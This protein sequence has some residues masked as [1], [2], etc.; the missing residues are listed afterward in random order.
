MDFTVFCVFILS[1]A[2]NPSYSSPCRSGEI[3]T[4]CVNPCN[5]CEYKGF[6]NA[7][8]ECQEGCDC[9]P[10]HY[11]NENGLCVPLDLCKAK[12][13]KCPK[14]AL[15]VPCAPPTIP[16]C[17]NPYSEQD[18]EYDCIPGCICKPGFL[19]RKDSTC[20]PAS[21]CYAPEVPPGQE[22]SCQ[23]NEDYYECTPTC[24]NTCQNFNISGTKCG[25]G[26]PGC[27]CKE[28]LVKRADG[29]CVHPQQCL[30]SP[31]PN[32]LSAQCPKNAIFIQC[33]SPCPPTCDD[34]Q[35]EPCEE[36][37]TTAC[38]C[39]PGYLK[40]KD[41]ICVIPEDCHPRSKEKI[42]QVKCPENAIFI[43]CGSP[44]PPTCEN[45]QP[46]P[47]EEK[48]TSACYC[49]PGYLKSKENKCVKPENCTASVLPPANCRDDEEYYECNPSCKNTCENFNNPGVKCQCGPPGCFCKRGLVKRADGK[50]ILPSQCTVPPP[51]QCTAYE[52]YYECTPSC[53]NTCEHFNNSR[54]RCPCGPPGCFCKPG[55]VKKADGKC[56][57][58]NQCVVLPPVN[59]APHEHFYE[60]TPSCKNTCENFNNPGVNCR[61]GP[62][63]CFC[64]KGLVKRMDGMCVLPS[65]CPVKAICR[66]NAQFSMCKSPCRPT[67]KNPSPTPCSESCVAGCFCKDGFLEDEDGSCVL[68]QNCRKNKVI[69]CG[70]DQKY[71]ECTPSCKNTCENFNN[72]SARCQCGPPGCFCKSGLVKRAD[73]KCVTPKECPV[74][75]V[76]HANAQFSMCKSPCRPT[77]KNPSPAPCTEPCV[78]GCFCKDGYVEDEDGRCVL[79][80]NCKKNCGQDEQF[81]ACTPNCK[82]T[83]ENFD[84]PGVRCQCGP[85]GCFCKEG[86]VKRADG[87]CVF[88]NQCPVKAS[89]RENAQFSMCRSPCRPTC[90]NPYPNPCNE[91]CVAGCFCKDGF[92]EDEDGSCVLFEKCKKMKAICRANAQFSMCRTPCRPTCKNPAP[93]PCNE[94]CVAGCFCTDGFV[95]DQDGRCVHFKNCTRP[96]PPVYCG[97]DEEYYQ[98]TPSCKNTCENFNNP[99]V[100]CQCGPPGCFCRKGLIK[101]A[102]GKCV[103]PDRCPACRANAQFS[104]CQPPCQPTCQN[105]YPAPCNKPCV[106]GCFCKPGF[107]EE[108]DGQCVLFQNCKK[109]CGQDEEYYECT[110]SCKNTCE[111]FN[112]PGVKCQC[113]P[114]GCFCKRGLIKRMD[115]KC[116]L[117]S[118]CPVKAICRAN[119]QFSMCKS[120]CRPTCKN[121]SPA[122]CNERCV[123]GCFCE[124]GYVEE[125]DGRCVLFQNCRKNCGQD[126]QYYE[127]TPSCKNTCD[128]FN[129]PGVRCQCGPPGCFCKE[130]LVKRADGK[131][132]HPRQ[133]PANVVCRTNAQFSMCQPPCRPTCQNPSPAPCNEP[134]VSGC[135]CKPGFVEDEDGTCVPYNN[136]KKNCGQDMQYYECTPSCKNTCENFKNPAAKCQCGPPGCFCKEGLVKRAD[137]KCVYPNQCPVIAV[138][139]ANAQFWMCKSPCRPTCDNPAPAPCNLPCVAGCFCKPGF[140]EDVDGRCVQFK[141]C[142]KSEYSCLSSKGYDTALGVMMHPQSGPQD[143]LGW[144]TPDLD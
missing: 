117:P 81:Y 88:P 41:G 74:K 126:E 138:C 104:E 78:A 86:L 34:L 32:D 94:P 127:C 13:M 31:S 75:A 121:P 115:G 50:C 33:G 15:Y 1:S 35:P 57:H 89:C 70:P 55:L 103:L 84:N 48:C 97:Q 112:N 132:V 29:K 44:C 47:C 46:E 27:F 123:S 90:K 10:Q 137:G 134:C 59:C 106:S 26:P 124:D 64:K 119:A 16:S 5:T 118:Q 23:E 73:G 63:G 19:K 105:P 17:E 38:Y 108:E 39:K 7:P 24:R 128:N 76:C 142:S 98:C 58:P 53:K 130:G 120:P 61:C 66:T 2:V 83:C 111:H 139:R 87:K 3:W 144:P 20:V 12:T 42:P 102:D 6:C 22:N 92:V 96:L 14:N 49:K 79:F 52:Q 125:E 43:Q 30:Q 141:N 109:N 116:V 113:G 62:P 101:R 129:N 36:K 91:P 140:V 136:C 135:F 77:C 133:C 21:Q 95:E 99:G 4:E 72:P 9:K 85:P 68:F 114:P 131:C 45:R 143:H 37:C 56:V 80:Q 110:P 11:R 122:P 82:N 54:I 69:H 8:S 18:Y 40:R 93:S 51:V 100:K 28:G 65:Q 67:C 60:C 71:Y 107:V 25:C